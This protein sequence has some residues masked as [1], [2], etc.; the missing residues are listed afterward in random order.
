[1]TVNAKLNTSIK[2]GG[3]PFYIIFTDSYTNYNK[4]S[5]KYGYTKYE[6]NAGGL[7]LFDEDTHTFII[8]LDEKD[9][10]M[11]LHEI[12]HVVI[13]LFHYI[14]HDITPAGSEPCCYMIQELYELAMQVYGFKITKPRKIIKRKVKNE[15]TTNV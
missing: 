14:G 6:G 11:L 10:F 12:N 9:P 2:I 8:M 7:E 4:I 5:A 13:D 15:I 3:Y 1:M